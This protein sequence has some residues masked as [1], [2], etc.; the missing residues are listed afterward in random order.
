M[1]A[2]AQKTQLKTTLEELL[3]LHAEEALALRRLARDELDALTDRKLALWEQLTAVC[4]Q[5]PPGPED[6]DA[7]ERIRHAAL[8]NQ[9]LLHHARDAIR[10]ILQNASGQAL[11]SPSNRPSAVQDGLRVDFRG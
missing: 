4:A 5:C 1:Q 2:E 11:S 10:T 3:L 9:I 8:H 7:L 6:R